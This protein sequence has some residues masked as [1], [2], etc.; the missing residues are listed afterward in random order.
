MASSLRSTAASALFATLAALVLWPPG[1]VYWDAVAA[2]VGDAVTLA[3]VAA[4]AVGLGAAFAWATGVDPVRFAAGGLVAYAVGMAAVEALLEPD[5]P[6]H[7]LGYA[8]LLCC[9]LTGVAVRATLRD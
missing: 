9:L 1:A 7:L 6:V 5:S 2:V 3:T 8:A 4:L